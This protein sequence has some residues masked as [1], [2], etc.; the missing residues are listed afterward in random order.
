MTT[1]EVLQAARARIAKGKSTE[2]F[3]RDAD[4][5]KV[6]PADWNAVAWCMVGATWYISSSRGRALALLGRVLMSGVNDSLGNL[7]DWS[8]LF[9]Y[10]DTHSQE[11]VL[12]IFDQAIVLSEAEGCL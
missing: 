4:G 1:L 11:E 2:A 9:Q 5:K 6:S 8:P 12:A 7:Y 10:N 3:A